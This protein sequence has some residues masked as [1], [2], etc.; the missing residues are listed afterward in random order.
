MQINTLAQ[1]VHVNNVV[2]MWV[3]IQERRKRA[4]IFLVK[5]PDFVYHEI[6]RAY[7]I[8]SYTN[9][10]RKVISYSQPLCIYSPHLTLALQNHMTL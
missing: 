1:H 4:L 10:A 6:H 9:T 5:C 7:A 2:F 8:A 3:E